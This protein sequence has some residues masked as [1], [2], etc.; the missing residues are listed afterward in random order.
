MRAYREAGFLTL[1]ILVTERAKPRKIMI[2]G[3]TESEQ[4]PQNKQFSG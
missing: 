4:E 1:R 2:G 3:A